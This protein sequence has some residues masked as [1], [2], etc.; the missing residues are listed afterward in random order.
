MNDGKQVLNHFLL[1]R[2]R[3]LIDCDDLAK[4]S[5]ASRP[6]AVALW[7]GGRWLARWLRGRPAGQPPR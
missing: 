1:W 3:F 7:L 5:R 4:F 2:Q 6:L